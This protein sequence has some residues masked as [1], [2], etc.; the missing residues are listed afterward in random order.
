MRVI[1]IAVFILFYSSI[2]SQDEVGKAIIKVKPANA[3]IKLEDSI[4]SNGQVYDLPEGI[5]AETPSATTLVIKGID[6]ELVGH[7]SSKIRSLRPPEPYKGKGIRY[8]DE[9]IIKKEAKKK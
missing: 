8:S 9:Q 3:L 4:L 1:F 2:F 5:T 6:N 7:V